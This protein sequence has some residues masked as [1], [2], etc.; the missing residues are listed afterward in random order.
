MLYN[1]QETLHLLD[2]L[3][4]QYGIQT[5][6]HSIRHVKATAERHLNISMTLLSGPISLAGLG[7]VEVG[8][9]LSDIDA[10]SQTFIRLKREKKRRTRN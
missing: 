9:S 1:G 2:W 3:T 8:S 6:G 10:I 4:H 7:D 5:A